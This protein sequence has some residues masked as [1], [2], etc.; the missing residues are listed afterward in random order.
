MYTPETNEY[1]TNEYFTIAGI[2]F[3]IAV[4]KKTQLKI[5]IKLIYGQ[6]TDIQN[7]VTTR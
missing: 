5:N 3:H 7:I 2:H 4:I 6:L 1:F